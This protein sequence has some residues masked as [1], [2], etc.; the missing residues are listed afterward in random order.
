MAWVVIWV[1]YCDIVR[2]IKGRTGSKKENDYEK[3]T[4]KK[5]ETVTGG[6]G[7]AEGCLLIFTMGMV[8]G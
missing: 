7:L 8:L 3:P 1:V 6:Y 4:K 2:M 5:K